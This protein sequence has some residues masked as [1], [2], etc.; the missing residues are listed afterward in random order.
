MTTPNIKDVPTNQQKCYKNRIG[1][2][3][4]GVQLN[5]TQEQVDMYVKCSKDPIFFIKSYCKIIHIDLG[6]IPFALYD[7]Q[8]DFINCIHN[9]SKTVLATARQVGKTMCTAAYLLWF[10]IF[11]AHKD[12]AVLA[13]KGATSK[14][15]MKKI[16]DMYCH[17]P[18][19]LQAGVIEFQKT[20]MIL[21]N[22][23]RIFCETT[24]A[25]S[26]R[27]FSISCMLLDEF[28]FVPTNNAEE[29][30]TSVWPTL[31]SG[32]DTKLI[33]ASCVVKDTYIFSE[34]GI[35]QIS[36]FI[37]DD[38]S[39]HTYEIPTYSIQGKDGIKTGCLMHTNGIVATKK[40]TSRYSLL[41]GSHNHKLYT[42]SNGVYDWHRLDELKVGDFIA[43]KYGMNI[44]GN[45]DSIDFNYQTNKFEGNRFDIEKITPD[46][47]YLLGLYIAE[48]NMANGYIDITCGDDVSHVFSDIGLKYTL[49]ADG[50]HYRCSSRSLVELMRFL[51]FDSK[52]TAKL[53]DI[54]KRL[55][56]MSKDNVVAL[57]QGMFDGD[58]CADKNRA[59]VSY[60]ST[61]LKLIEQLRV[62]LINFGVLSTVTKKI[63]PPTERV[64]VYST[65]WVLT[66]AN[67]HARTFFNEVGFR[68]ARKQSRNVVCK[69]T[70]R[71]NW[72][73]IIPN[74][75]NIFNEIKEKHKSNL[76]I[77]GGVAKRTIGQSRTTAIAIKDK[78]NSVGITEQILDDIIQPD[79]C[80]IPILSIEDSENYTYDF[81]LPNDKSDKWAHSVIYNGI[82]GHQTPNGL[83][84]FY[85]TYQEAVDG[86]NGFTP[87]M[88]RWDVVPGRDDKW[89]A[90]Q[91][92]V[93]GDIKFAQEMEVDFQGSSNTLISS[94]YI[95]NMVFKTPI[96]SADGFDMLEKPIKDH[97]YMITVDT[98]RG[99]ESD[100]SAV[101]VFDATSMPYRT[102]GKY[103][104]DHIPPILFPTIIHK[105]A[106]DYNMAHVLIENN[107]LGEQVVGILKNDL[108]YE[109]I[110]HVDKDRVSDWARSG[111]PGI[112]TTL[113]TKR[114]GCAALKTLVENESLI[115][116][117][118]DTI[119][120]IS[121]FVQIR[122]CF[123]A[124][125]SC[126]DDLCM[127]L[128]LFAWLSNQVW[129]RD[130]TDVDIRKIMFAAETLRLENEIIPP[131][132]INNGEDEVAAVEVVVTP[133]CIWADGRISYNDFVRDNYMQFER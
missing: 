53:K 93:L 33:I 21:E 31:S 125:N 61:S 51:G 19:W 20:S 103:R 30:F 29:F 22:G 113:K 63:T 39:R 15:I 96:H 52:K 14:E 94:Y 23:S 76:N 95:K 108:E 79:I 36:D 6:L 27:G 72:L 99:V 104:S 88:V 69:D 71:G 16:Q 80:W 26:I 78:F 56:S 133:D 106:T 66:I 46:F 105:I 128:I 92:R 87:L 24:S 81:S 122:G 65:A 48:G 73:D 115:I 25:N 77:S 18:Y 102:V 57:L 60:T 47:S 55:F 12:S 9:N 32:K 132:F 126:H 37:D 85:K 119:V 111:T 86:R 97:I 64:N 5:F 43:M 11:N 54:P 4:A 89:A 98:A 117:D 59:R 121:T 109:N 112:K 58:G 38:H 13:N 10:V 45:D 34:N 74:S 90:D 42:Y 120:E 7:Y 110:I 49:G 116:T 127:C 28:A 62:I 44:W 107:D 1:V 2:K 3:A 130:F 91:R 100:F 83:N 17:I 41:E 50:L 40:I 8:E 129:F 101:M 123:A 68:F 124:D 75:K 114:M 70:Y 131:G 82:L 118:F 84:H 67:S 35:K